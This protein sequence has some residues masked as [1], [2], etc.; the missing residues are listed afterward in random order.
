M[1][2]RRKPTVRRQQL[3]M[4]CSVEGGYSPHIRQARRSHEVRRLTL[5]TK[6]RSQQPDDILL[7]FSARK[8]RLGPRDVAKSE[9]IECCGGLLCRICRNDV[10]YPL[11]RS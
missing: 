1:A 8:K 7:I 6:Y 5:A 9:G 2:F 10:I 11:R 4:K 3:L